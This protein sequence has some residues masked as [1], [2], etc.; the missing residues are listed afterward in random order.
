LNTTS[1]A[2]AARPARTAVID[3]GSNSV[4]LI[5]GERQREELRILE[6]VRTPMPLGH[7]VFRSGSISPAAAGQVLAT[8]ERCCQMMRE[9]DVATVRTV[10][11]TA[12]REARNRDVI[13]DAIRRRSG[14]DVT[15]L[16]AGDVV[17]Y[18]DAY[19]FFRMGKSLPVRRQVILSAEIGA[20]TSD[21]SVMR[22]GAVLATAGLPLG[23]LRLTQMIARASA[24][25]H[26]AGTALREYV[27]SELAGLRRQLPRIRPQSIVLFSESLGSVLESVLG[28]S[29][30]GE[31]LMQLSRAQAEELWRLC[32]GRHAAELEE[33]YRLAPDTAEVL[34]A[35]AAT[36]ATLLATFERDELF[37]V[38]T[39]LGE[40]LLTYTLFDL[41]R[42]ERYDKLRQ[43]LSVARSL[44]YRHG[45]DLGH[46]R[47]VGM[48]ARQLFDG[49]RVRLGLER[50]DLN[51]LLIA[52]QLHDIGKFV[53]AS[54]HH[55]HSEYLI[56]ALNLFRLNEEEVKLI[57]CVARYHRRSPPRTAH[58]LYAALAAPNRIKVQKLAALLRLADALDRSHTGRVEALRVRT[59]ES[60]AVEVH[61]RAAAEPLLE[62]LSFEMKK[63]LFCEIAGCDVRLV[64]E[65]QIL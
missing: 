33:S 60:G 57:A 13:L 28:T 24:D 32:R 29:E 2:S 47:R 23:M 58:P 51:Y 45:A 35:T 8:I 64:V 26:A 15:V 42:A 3:I 37:V 36:V 18:F 65:R 61:V 41:G 16:T 34:E 27:E 11:T 53:S 10:A 19:L 48:F 54:A 4:R 49:L 63:D 22:R 46:A 38:Q 5:V 12:V 6:S 44:C 43:Q 55:K 62:R 56:A 20:G 30:R 31:G 52:A 25:A 50:D 21:F 59:T 40:A 7:E 14:L 39:S 17:Y 9:Y 1:A